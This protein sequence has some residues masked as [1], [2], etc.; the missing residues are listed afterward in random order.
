[1]DFA[2]QRD[3]TS[4]EENETDVEEIGSSSLKIADERSPVQ[5]GFPLKFV[6]CE[7]IMKQWLPAPRVKKESWRAVLVLLTR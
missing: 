3:R 5:F 4:A 1:M 2:R 7:V 6:A